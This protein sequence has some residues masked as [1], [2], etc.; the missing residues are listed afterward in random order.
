M[1]D[2]PI[3]GDDGEPDP[4]DDD[5]DSCPDLGDNSNS[6]ESDDEDFTTDDGKEREVEYPASELCRRQ[7]EAWKREPANDPWKKTFDELV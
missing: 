5:E 3:A 1:H 2:T 7:S 4:S 6:D